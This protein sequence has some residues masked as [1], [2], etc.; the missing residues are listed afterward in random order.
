[1]AP[2]CLVLFNDGNGRESHNHS[3]HQREHAALIDTYWACAAGKEFTAT[4]ATATTTST[5]ALASK[6]LWSLPSVCRLSRLD[7]SLDGALSANLRAA[8]ART[9]ARGLDWVLG[10]MVRCG[11]WIQ[12]ADPG[13]LRSWR[14]SGRTVATVAFPHVGRPEL[15]DG[16]ERQDLALHGTLT[17]C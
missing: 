7:H 5:Q 6:P 2:G 9:I 8:T 16:Y 13:A 1:M 4:A 17:H 14:T 12:A 3:T 15:E 11:K 10:G